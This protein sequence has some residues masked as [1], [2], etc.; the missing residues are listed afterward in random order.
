MDSDI[1]G[2][3]E[4]EIND[5]L[6]DYFAEIDADYA[7]QIEPTVEYFE[8]KGP[9]EGVHESHDTLIR[10]VVTDKNGVSRH[11]WTHPDESESPPAKHS[12][13]NL[14]PELAK[15]FPTDAADAATWAKVK[16]HVTTLHDAIYGAMIRATPRILELARNVLDTPDDFTKF[17]FAPTL[18]GTQHANVDPIREATG[19][20]THLVLNLTSKLLA[21][22]YTWAKSQARKEGLDPRCDLVAQTADLILGL[23]QDV[24]KELGVDVVLSRDAIV[25][26]LMEKSA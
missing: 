23:L 24:A 4:A 7:A 5:Q 17:G 1:P 21:A 16:A 9:P 6:A 12:V 10:K 15:H 8:K 2:F 3:S 22:G 20:S 18:S 13:T 11:V 19:L 26:A 25:K 14:L